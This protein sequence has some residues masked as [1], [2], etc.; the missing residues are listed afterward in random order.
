[1]RRS[2]G[3]LTCITGVVVRKLHLHPL[4]PFTQVPA[5]VVRKGGGV[6]VVVRVVVVV[7]R[8]DTVVVVHW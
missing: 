3:G 1:M 6:V 7:V 5:Q 4:N 8:E 2:R